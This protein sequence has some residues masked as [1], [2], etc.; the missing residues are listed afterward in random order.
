MRSKFLFVILGLFFAL[1][2]SAKELTLMLFGP[3]NYLYCNNNPVNKI[4][5][6]GLWSNKDAWEGTK[7]MGDSVVDTV[8]SLY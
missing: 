4:D 3:N 6:L 1:N 8:E 5:H 2:L 7:G